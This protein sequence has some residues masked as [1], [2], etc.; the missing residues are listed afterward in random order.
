M[1]GIVSNMRVLPRS[2]LTLFEAEQ[3][4]TTGTQFGTKA[5]SATRLT[6]DSAAKWR[7]PSIGEKCQLRSAAY[8]TMPPA[9]IHRYEEVDHKLIWQSVATELDALI[10]ALEPLIPPLPPEI[11]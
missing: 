4:D 3:P 1:R 9:H 2:E 6:V 7:T 5:L 8:E 11:P 10:A